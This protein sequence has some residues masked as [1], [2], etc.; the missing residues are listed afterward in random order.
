M[1]RRKHRQQAAR[2]CC[3]TPDR[4]PAQPATGPYDCGRVSDLTALK[5]EWPKLARETDVPTRPPSS[6]R[7]ARAR[8]RES[9]VAGGRRHQAADAPDVGRADSAAAADDIGAERDPFGGQPLK[10]AVVA[11]LL[12]YEHMLVRPDDLSRLDAAFF[13]MNGYIS[14]TIFL[15][16]LADALL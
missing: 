10:V 3:A 14:V 2:R 11:G 9:G 12:L 4:R 8:G 13:N 15:F 5:T 1:T 7:R 6:G 16:T